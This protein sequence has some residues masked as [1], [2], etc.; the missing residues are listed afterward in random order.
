MTVISPGYVKTNLS[1]NALTASGSL[2]G[3]MDPETANGYTPDFIAE[4][5]FK[6]IV[7]GEK[8]VL[9]T[10]LLPKL[11]IFLRYLLPNLYFITMAR[12]AR[13]KKD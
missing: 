8:D 3:Q 7:N 5:T 11:A 1:I 6:A 12:R 4:R 2:H 13:S 10:P 9:V